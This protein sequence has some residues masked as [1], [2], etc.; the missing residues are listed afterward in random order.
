MRYYVCCPTLYRTTKYKPNQ[1]KNKK[2]WGFKKYFNP[3]SFKIMDVDL[4]YYF[5]F[6]NILEI[7]LATNYISTYEQRYNVK[8][9]AKNNNFLTN[10]IQ[11][12]FL[13]S[14]DFKFSILVPIQFL[15]QKNKKTNNKQFDL[16]LQDLEPFME[17]VMVLVLQIPYDRILSKD[18]EW[19]DSILWK[20]C[21]CYS[22]SVAIEF[23]HYS[24]YQDLT[25]NI[26]KKYNVSLIWS[27]R[28]RYHYPVYTS[29]FLYLRINENGKKWIK[30]LKDREKDDKKIKTGIKIQNNNKDNVAFVQ[31]IID[32]AIIVVES[33]D[34]SQINFILKSLG[35]PVLTTKI[36]NNINKIKNKEQWIDKVILH[37]DINSFFSSCEEIR[38]PMLKGRAHAV[39]MTNEENNNITKGVVAACSYE[40]KK[41]GVKSA[42]PLYRAL[43]LC[44]DLIL[45][46]VDK[47]FYTKISYQVMKIL[48]EYADIFEQASI[49]EGYL[50]CT[51]RIISNNLHPEQLAQEIKRTIKKQC[52]GL[53]TSIGVSTTKSIAKIA[54]DYQKP[55][56]LTVIPSNELKNYLDQLDVDRISGIGIKTQKIL[57]EEMEIKTIGKLANTDVQIL[58]DRFGKK[59]GT[60]M[61]KVANGKNDDP[62]TPR[63]DYISMGNESTLEYFTLDRKIIKQFLNK[64]MDE[65]LERINNKKYKFKTVGIKLVRTDFT[66]ET[67]EKSFTTYQDTRKSI[68]YAIDDLLDRV[69]LTDSPSTSSSLFTSKP[70]NV[71]N[72]TNKLL[73]VRKI[74]LRVSNLIKID[75]NKEIKNNQTTLM[76]YF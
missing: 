74:G 46:A 56:G 60:W 26:L 49:D 3:S 12:R 6:F 55:D 30:T 76:D 39:I 15:E 38:N 50:D 5:K 52:S 62:V 35:F 47:K 37:V 71:K 19:L 75:N 10:I 25:Y 24:W 40:A 32:Y 43:E 9:I 11:N 27:D 63:T 42:M 33:N 57:K 58:I 53:S 65:L 21:V 51:K 16:F 54:S 61:W 45:N 28:N 36:N 4:N 20:C 44:P 64:L 23:E 29:N 8:H 59:T 73:P 18:K 70:K 7:E 67:R 69:I 31:N 66:I 48:E 13:N 68:E 34:S 2:D 1:Q 22:Y 14:P 17:N 41:T 72:V